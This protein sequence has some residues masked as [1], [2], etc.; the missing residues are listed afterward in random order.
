[1]E[2]TKQLVPLLSSHG[3]T[4]PGPLTEVSL[5]NTPALVTSSES[6]AY[7]INLQHSYGTQPSSLEPAVK[8]KKI[9][10]IEMWLSA[11]HIFVGVYTSKYPHESPA[12]MKYGDVV[13]DLAA[14]GHNW[15]FYDNNFRFL[16][17]TQATS[18]PW[19]N[20]HWELWLWSQSTPL[21][22]PPPNGSSQTVA[23]SGRPFL[24]I[25]RGYCY[26][27]HK[28][29]E[30]SG[31]A[32]K[33]SCFRCDGMHPATQCNFRTPSKCTNKPPLAAK[34]SATNSNKN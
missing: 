5:G 29:G 4:D 17:Q 18:L 14:R 1:M 28:G 2:V 22:K 6:T 19:G 11:F 13:Q 21:K 24:H 8:P 26:K 34:S 31:C 10:N 12:L 16:R 27:Y 3:N 33:H 7:Q 20:I 32:F 25:P 9:H 15:K 23:K 30:C